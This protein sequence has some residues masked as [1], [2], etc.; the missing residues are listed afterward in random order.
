MCVCVRQYVSKK[1]I[2]TYTY[3]YIQM[4]TYVHIYTY[5]YTGL[6]V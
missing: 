1:N 4:F 3:M 6:R 2:W 5:R